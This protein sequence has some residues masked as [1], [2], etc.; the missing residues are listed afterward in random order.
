MIKECKICKMAFKASRKN[1]RF[2][3]VR[4]YRKSPAARA[5]QKV[6]DASPAKLKYWYSEA[7]RLAWRRKCQQEANSCGFREVRSAATNN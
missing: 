3:S 7:G 2:C 4:C 5:W 1:A 6:Y